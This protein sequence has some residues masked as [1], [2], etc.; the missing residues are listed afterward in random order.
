MAQ[1]R[2]EKSVTDATSKRGAPEDE[3]QAAP[4]K[5]FVQLSP[6]QDAGEWEKDW[7]AGRLVGLNDPTPY[8]YGRARQMGCEVAFSQKLRRA[9]IRN[10]LRIAFRVLL[11]F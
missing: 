8:G 5:V 7:A 1:L 11:G 4:I 10:L 6:S 3:G 9:P 2:G